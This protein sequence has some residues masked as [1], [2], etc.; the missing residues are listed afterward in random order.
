MVLLSFLHKSRGLSFS[1]AC[2][3]FFHKK[4]TKGARIISRLSHVYARTHAILLWRSNCVYS[5]ARVSSSE[6]FLSS[7]YFLSSLG[8]EKKEEGKNGG[9]RT[10]I[11]LPNADWCSCLSLSVSSLSLSSLSLSVIHAKLSL[12]FFH[13]SFSP[14]KV[15][16]MQIVCPSFISSPPF[17]ACLCERC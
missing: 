8:K 11:F 6:K 3:S 4:N 14:P 17:F 1:L 12:Y 7:S 2:L 16:I 10:T 5:C 15:K 9:L 13:V